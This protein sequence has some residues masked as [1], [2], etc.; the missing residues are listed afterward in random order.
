MLRLIDSIRERWQGETD[1]AGL[2]LVRILVAL[3][4]LLEMLGVWFND[5]LAE[6]IVDP[7]I[8][9]KYALFEWIGPPQGLMPQVFVWTLAIIAG[10]V[11]IGWR[12]RWTASLMAAGYIYWFLIDAANYTDHAY[13]V[14]L[15][16]VL[17]AWLPTNRWASV[18]AYVEREKRTQVP[19]WTVE[20]VRTQLALVYFFFA[21]SMLNSDWLS[22]APLIAWA[23]TE[24]DNRAAAIFAGHPSLVLWLARLIPVL[25]LALIPGLCWKRTRGFALVIVA[26]FHVWD[27]FAFHLSVSPWFLTGL[28]L[29]FCDSARWRSWGLALSTWLSR[30]SIVNLVWRLLCKLGRLVDACVSWFDDTPLVGEAQAKSSTRK[31]SDPIPTSPVET[32]PTSA[33]WAVAVWM[34][35]Q[36]WMPVR[37]VTLE[38]RPDWTDLAST[39]AWRGQHRDKQCELKMSVIQPSQELRWPLD[40]TDEFPVPQAIFYTDE[41]LESMGLSEGFLKDL[42]SGPEETRG[43][44]I[45]A[46]KLPDAEA[47]R[48]FIN[49]RAS[50]RLRLATHQYEQLVQRPELI[51]QYAHRIGQVLS[52]QLKEEVQVHANLLVKL[53]HRPAQRMLSDQEDFD[54]LNIPTVNALA[55]KLARLSPEL[56]PVAE[57]VAS[58][59]EWAIRRRMEL[60]QEYDIVPEKDRRQGEPIKL[61]GF[62]EE[63]ERWYQKTFARTTPSTAKK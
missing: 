12:T 28:S 36:C 24:A 19:A 20:L 11:A 46:L 9:F 44:R 4:V 42:V 58:A 54:L 51:R 21:I 17:V 25:Y 6:L 30:W 39:F 10:M 16:S 26:L 62:S 49:H 63:D 13:L 55:Q 34:V 33:R 5:S 45:E 14:C 15:M 47:E 3:C 59:K 27:Q 41:Q 53:N 18:D 7:Q 48:I 31:F 1:G 61:P 32:F 2:G 43:A 29:V 52:E 35:L 23:E 40:P 57:R 37:Y 56:P 60:E 22:G 38:A 8:H 50:V